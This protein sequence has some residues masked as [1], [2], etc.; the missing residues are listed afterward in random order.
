M[1]AVWDLA[2]E[3]FIPRDLDKYAVIEAKTTGYLWSPQTGEIKTQNS[4]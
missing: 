4:L 3:D 2:Y 1:F